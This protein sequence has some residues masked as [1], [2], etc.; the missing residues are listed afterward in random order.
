MIPSAK[1]VRAGKVTF[2][3][4]NAGTIEHE[5]VVLRTERHHHALPVK[6][7]RAVEMGLQ[8]EVE[9][10][11]PGESARLTIALKPGKYVLLC[12]LLGHYKAGQFAALRAR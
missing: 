4:K 5:L 2:L 11:E 7:G 8:G 12:N 1:I 10:L 3:V 6:G 9:E